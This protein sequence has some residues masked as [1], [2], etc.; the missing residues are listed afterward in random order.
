M[1]KNIGK[2]ARQTFQTIDTVLSVALSYLV[3]VFTF[4]LY[5]LGTSLFH[6]WDFVMRFG[7]RKQEIYENTDQDNS[8][9]YMIR[10]VLWFKDTEKTNRFNLFINHYITSTDQYISNSWK[11][12]GLILYGTL[13]EDK[14][15]KQNKEN[16]EA[17]VTT[18]L[19]RMW[20]STLHYPEDS[21]KYIIKPNTTCWELVTTKKV[22]HNKSE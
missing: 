10:Y 18:T 21:I 4:V 14:Q 11:S 1:L 2:C 17:T 13:R 7:G 20:N 8:N 15:N 9:L 6:M 12:R 3:M 16:K 5:S 22:E 19:R